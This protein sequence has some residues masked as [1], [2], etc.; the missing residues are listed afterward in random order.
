LRLLQAR[1]ATFAASDIGMGSI[2]DIQTD[3]VEWLPGGTEEAVA[4]GKQ[5][6]NSIL[7][8]KRA[9]LQRYLFPR[10]LDLEGCC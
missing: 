10:P 5:G 4:F 2:P 8:G 1:S 3:E 9:Q 7:G 6:R